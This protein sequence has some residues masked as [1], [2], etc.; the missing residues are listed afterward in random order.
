[1]DIWTAWTALLENGIHLLSAQLGL[2]EA[3]AIIALTL[4]AR[5]ALMPLSFRAAYNMYQ[6][7][8]AIRDAKPE[9][10]HLK[11]VY[12]DNP[13]EITKRTMALYKK[14]GIKF[15]GKT[16]VFNIGSQSLLGLG[17][18]QTLKNMTF[19]SKFL[20]ISN[21]GKP[22]VILALAV[23]SLMFAS[24]FLTPGTAEQASLLIFLIPV[25]ISVF[26]L[27]SFPS[28]IGVYWATS[29]FA[30]LAQSLYLRH[31]VKPIKGD[32]GIKI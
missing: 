28:A 24:M 5:L 27:V 23:G 20:W 30:T 29:N 12:K 26:V 1:M 32:G 10:E 7:Q 2:S 18:F 11:E 3:L 25:A 13:S 22:D 9:I 8:M 31:V 6:N 21:L 4:F 15:L 16:M 14:R 17:L 19:S